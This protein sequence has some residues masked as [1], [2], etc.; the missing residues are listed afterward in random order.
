MRKI[1]KPWGFEIIWAETDDY[2]A[3]F[4]YITQKNSRQRSFGRQTTQMRLRS[5]NTAAVVNTESI[6]APIERTHE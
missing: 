6:A 1:E 2:V 5:K 4:L 3:K